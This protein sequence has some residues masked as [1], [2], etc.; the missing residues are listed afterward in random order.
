MSTAGETDLILTPS[1]EKLIIGFGTAFDE[2]SANDGET[3]DESHFARFLSDPILMGYPKILA[4]HET[5]FDPRERL[6]FW[7]AFAAVA[8]N[9]DLPAGLVALGAFGESPGASAMAGYLAEGLD[10]WSLSFGAKDVSEASDRSSYWIDEVSLTKR[11]AVPSSRILRVGAS[12]P[13]VWELCTESP[14][15]PLPQRKARWVD[16]PPLAIVA[17]RTVRD[18]WLEPV[19]EY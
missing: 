3:Y 14:M 1:P 15:P 19:S 17:G 9:G 13:D 5:P 10:G 8:A 18:R 6:G 16:G 11:P 2:P 12:V 4:G 7:F